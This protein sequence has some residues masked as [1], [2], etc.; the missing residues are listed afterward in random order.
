M[1]IKTIKDDFGMIIDEII[2]N[3][4]E[5]APKNARFNVAQKWSRVKFD[6]FVCLMDRILSN[7]GSD[8]DFK[9]LEELLR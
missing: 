6:N 4:I 8:E 9:K 1:E 5:Q 7:K 3:K 2:T